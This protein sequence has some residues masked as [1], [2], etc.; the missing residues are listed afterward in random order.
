MI[1][2]GPQEPVNAILGDKFETTVTILGKDAAGSLVLP[3]TPVVVR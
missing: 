2:L 3:D 1:V